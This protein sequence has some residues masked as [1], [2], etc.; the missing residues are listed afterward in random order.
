M[1]EHILR[2]GN[3]FLGPGGNFEDRKVEDSDSV[4]LNTLVEGGEGGGYKYYKYTNQLEMGSDMKLII[5][6]LT[7]YSEPSGWV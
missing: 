4:L 3:D 6:C 5:K 2:A 1:P 7:R